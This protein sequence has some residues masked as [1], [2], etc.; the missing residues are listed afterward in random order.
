MCYEGVFLVHWLFVIGDTLGTVRYIG[1]SEAG[2]ALRRVWGSEGSGDGGYVR[3][4]VQE[5]GGEVCPVEQ[6]LEAR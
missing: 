2:C 6:N 1:E 5:V 3:C 4:P